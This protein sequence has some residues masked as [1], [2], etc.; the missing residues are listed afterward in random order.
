MPIEKGEDINPGKMM[1]LQD[2]NNN[3]SISG[4]SYSGGYQDESEN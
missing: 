1:F 3:I 4:T 2:T